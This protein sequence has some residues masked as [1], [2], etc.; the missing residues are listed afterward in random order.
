MRR[1]ILTLV[2]I[3]LVVMV[4]KANAQTNPF[5]GKWD[6]T[7]QAAN[8]EYPCW[9]E[10]KDEGGKL[11]GWFLNRSGSVLKLPEISI[12]ND[13]LEF[14]PARGPNAPKVVHRATVS[15]GRLLG[16]A[17]AGAGNR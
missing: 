8:G 4:A 5:L 3:V 2:I 11:A 15:E 13:V 14:S 17:A 6:I 16:S 10:V 9:L 7:V 1:Q 12:Q